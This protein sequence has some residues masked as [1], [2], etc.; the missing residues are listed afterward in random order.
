MVGQVTRKATRIEN[1][2]T[3]VMFAA[4]AASIPSARVLQCCR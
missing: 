1:V 3:F 4:A 2:A